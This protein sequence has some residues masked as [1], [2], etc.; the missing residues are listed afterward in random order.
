MNSL[1]SSDVNWG[2]L[3]ETNLSGR[4]FLDYRLRNALVVSLVDVENDILITSG[5]LLH[6]ST[7]IR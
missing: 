6:A 4:P 7:T 2:P 1:N 3:S 5:H